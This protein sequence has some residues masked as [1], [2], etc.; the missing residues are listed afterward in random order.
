MCSQISFAILV[1]RESKS[2]AVVDSVARLCKLQDSEAHAQLI[3]TLLPGESQESIVRKLKI[4]NE[5]FPLLNQ[6]ITELMNVT[7][8]F[9]GEFA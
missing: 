7:G 2:T 8:Q 6:I 3:E 9:W 5:F 1:G 4:H